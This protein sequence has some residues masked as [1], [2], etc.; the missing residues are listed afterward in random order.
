MGGFFFF[1]GIFW[2]GFGL[3]VGLCSNKSIWCMFFGF[4][5]VVFVEGVLDWEFKGIVL[6]VFLFGGRVILILFLFS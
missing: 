4:D 5:V 1:R 2:G 3:C 6:G